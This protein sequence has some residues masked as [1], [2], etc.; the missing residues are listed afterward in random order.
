MGMHIRERMLAGAAR[1]P[2]HLERKEFNPETFAQEFK[3][4]FDAFTKTV[5]DYQE[6]N[7][8][9]VAEVE[10]KAGAIVDPVTKAELKAMDDKLAEIKTAINAEL[11][12]LKRPIISGEE[13]LTDEQREYKTAFNGYFRHGKGAKDQDNAGYET[14]K[15]LERKAMSVDNDPAGGF[16]V[17]PQI[18][19]TIDETLKQVSAMRAIAS[20]VQIGT[21]RYVR[22]VNIHGTDSGWVGERDARTATNNSLL[23]RLEFPVY[24]IYA[25]PQSTQT[26]LDDSNVNIEQWIAD[27]VSLE[28]AYQEGDAFING[29]GVNKPRGIL[30]YTIIANSSYPA[31]GSTT[32]ITWQ[33]VGYIPTG[34][35]AD[36]DATVKADC[37]V[38]L[39]HALKAPY[40]PGASWIMNNTTLAKARKLKDGQGNYLVNST[41][42]ASGGGVVETLMGKPVVEMPN[43]PDPAANSYS[44][45]FGN[46]PRAYQIVDR[47]GIRTLRDPYSNKP[48]IQFYTTKRVGGGVRNFE[49]FKL[50]KFAAS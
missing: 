13:K 36:F 45:A 16:T 47:I 20:T 18:E 32:P 34:A 46:W 4:Q 27:E 40:R 29:N 26:L 6:K 39:Y 28:F 19:A 12:K 21:D 41:L 3:T 10:K 43:M 7:D 31:Q 15:V 17:T 23:S 37:L 11:A 2:H 35:S 25:M 30:A 22:L 48:Y 38:D 24:E 42:T 9:A 50:L 44:A 1:V 5:K 8:K 49:A 33:Q 14:L